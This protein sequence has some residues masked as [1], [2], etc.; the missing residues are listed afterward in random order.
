MGHAVSHLAWGSIDVDTTL[1]RVF[2]QQD[3]RYS[4]EFEAPKTAWTYPEQLAFHTKV[5]RQIWSAWS[6][7]VTLGVS[8][9]HWMVTRF[10]RSGLPINFDVRWRTANQTTQWSIRA[11]KTQRTIDQG[12]R[13]QVVFLN[14]ECDLYANDTDPRGAGNDAG[15][16]RK[17]F[18]TPP[19]EFGHMLGL[20]DEYNVGSADLSDTDSIM[21]I[22][23]YIRARHMVEV[24]Q[25]LGRMFPGGVFSVKSIR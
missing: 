20:P 11:V 8:G 3:W 14:R 22:G 1:G 7:R 25:E 5:D 21:N 10:G 6:Y 23:R 4:W 9:N 24:L 12:A 19:H 16:V 13:S 18:L 15:A 17:N 2:F